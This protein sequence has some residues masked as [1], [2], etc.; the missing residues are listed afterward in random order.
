VDQNY[1]VTWFPYT[2]TC[3]PSCVNGGKCLAPDICECTPDFRGDHCQHRKYIKQK[4]NFYLTS[5]NIIP[6][7]AT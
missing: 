2:A 5:T 7:Y 1:N 3:D 6:K 4:I